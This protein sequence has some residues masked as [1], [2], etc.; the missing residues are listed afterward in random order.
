M[1][2]N[3]LIFPKGSQKYPHISA[4]PRTFQKG[5]RFISVLR[6]TG[7]LPNEITSH[8]D[9]REAS[10]SND[11]K[12]RQNSQ[13]RHFF[14]F[15]VK[16]PPIMTWGVTK[17]NGIVAQAQNYNSRYSF[18]K[19]HLRAEYCGPIYRRSESDPL[20]VSIW[21]LITSP[22]YGLLKLRGQNDQKALLSF[23]FTKAH[24]M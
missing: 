18:L 16:A 20:K 10:I 4:R 19:V 5:Q 21:D 14:D 15:L 13:K 22:C 7:G 1:T 3:F 23:N 2:F 12:R 6:R 8:F 17:R 9:I 11:Q 24:A